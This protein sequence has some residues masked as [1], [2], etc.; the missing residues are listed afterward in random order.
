MSSAAR[1]FLAISSVAALAFS[2]LL[3]VPAEDLSASEEEGDGSVAD[4]FRID[5]EE[6]LRRIGT[7]GMGLDKHYVQTADIRFPEDD[8]PKI[9]VSSRR[10]SQ[11]TVFEVGARIPSG[12]YA[13]MQVNEYI[14]SCQGGS[15]NVSFTVPNNVFLDESTVSIAYTGLSGTDETV[16]DNAW[17]VS[18]SYRQ[19]DADSVTLPT[20]GNFSPIGNRD[21]PFT[22]I[23]DGAGF[24]IEGIRAMDYRNGDTFSGLFGYAEGATIR[25]V[26]LVGSGSVFSSNSFYQS[27]RTNVANESRIPTSSAG[28]ICADAL[29]TAIENCTSTGTVSSVIIDI[30]KAESR[31]NGDLHQNIVRIESFAGGIIGNA[32]DCVIK[33]SSFFGTVSSL[34][35]DEKG[36]VFTSVSGGTGQEIFRLKMHQSGVSCIGGMAGISSGSEIIFCG[37]DSDQISGNRFFSENTTGSIDLGG[38]SIEIQIEFDC[39]RGGMAGFS[40]RDLIIGCWNGGD[41]FGEEQGRMDTSGLP[42]GTGLSFSHR[43]SQN[44][45]GIAGMMSGTETVNCLN[46]GQIG[47]S[48]YT[49]FQTSPYPSYRIGGI[50]GA[51]DQQ[52]VIIKN[53]FSDSGSAKRTSGGVV[54]VSLYPSLTFPGTY[55]TSPGLKI[56][57]DQELQ[58]DIDETMLWKAHEPFRDKADWDFERM[59]TVDNENKPRLQLR[60]DLIFEYLYPN[61]S[62]EADGSADS[63]SVFAITAPTASFRIT[64]G[65][66]SDSYYMLR[67][68]SN[69]TMVLSFSETVHITPDLDA[70]GSVKDISLKVSRHKIDLFVNCLM[71][72]LSLEPAAG[73]VK[74]MQTLNARAVAAPG[75]S[76]PETIE[77]MHGKVM[78]DA[79]QY[80]FDPESGDIIVPDVREDISI[81]AVAV[82]VE[83]EIIDD[84]DALKRIADLLDKNKNVISPSMILVSG[85]LVSMY[86]LW[87]IRN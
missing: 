69:E 73:I 80:T 47:R 12:F 75:F 21:R 7:G 6:D 10:G 74:C 67:H 50:A 78:L 1:R 37:N 25:N 53:C 16:S 28:S 63:G 46:T 61:M 39:Y 55:F 30:S 40:Q 82:P 87:S 70:S 31:S 2:I 15:E 65:V 34:L 79:T 29:R 23:Y 41:V 60:Y 3:L 52:N 51:T 62:I 32:N 5:S 64:P 8:G 17:S 11:T 36:L 45:G 76:L 72:N 24:K 26:S 4:P 13:V 56:I 71:E 68:G 77:V 14:A 18:F 48:G 35:F 54:G 9:S 81:R 20:R 66:D 49:N 58:E 43:G 83:K 86:G 44:S 59:W 85:L 27:L 42:A 38:S 19:K 84:G 57:S 22:G 33:S